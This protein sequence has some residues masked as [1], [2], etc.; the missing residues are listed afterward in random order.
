M[1]K[2]LNLSLIAL[3][4]ALVAS[5]PDSRAA[6]LLHQYSFSNGL[7]DAVGGRNGIAENGASV[8]HGALVLD[9][10]DDFVQFDTHLISTS[11]SY[12]VSLFANQA[13]VQTNY[14]EFISQGSTGGP[15]YYIGQDPNRLIR[16]SDSWLN[17]GIHMPTPGAWHHYAVTVDSILGTSRLFVD[18]MAV[19]TL[20]SAIVTTTGGTD[21]RLGAQ[22][23]NF[24][25]YFNGELDEIEIYSGAL[26]EN[27]IASLASVK[28]GVVPIPTSGLLLLSALVG[29]GGRFSRTISLLRLES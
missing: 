18:G 27:E 10:V 12:S 26:S 6:A 13:I 19:A 29:L 14:I 3:G 4:L 24:G 5:S 9:G 15:G 16:A 1:T 22:F 25:E 21:T 23:Q 17:T 8:E 7:I 2:A 11:G 28:P 20:H